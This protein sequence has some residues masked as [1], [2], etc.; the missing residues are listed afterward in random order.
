MRIFKKILFISIIFFLCICCKTKAEKEKEL[1]QTKKICNKYEDQYQDF[2]YINNKLG[3]TLEFNSDWIINT[4]YEDFDDFQKKYAKYFASELS[5]VLFV[6]YNNEKKIGIRGTCE[7]LGLTNEEYFEVIKTTTEK[8]IKNYKIKFIE[9]NDE[10][11]FKNIKAFSTIFETTIN[12]NNI[13]VFTSVLLNKNDINY[14]ID[15]WIKKDFYEIEKNYI[16]SVLDTIDFI[17][18]ENIQTSDTTDDVEKK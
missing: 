9:E 18:I 4:Q 2:K 17:S 8:E 16:Y 10:A 6:G 5:E 11:I 12:P 1:N 14:K 7:S 15:I 3:L 13:F